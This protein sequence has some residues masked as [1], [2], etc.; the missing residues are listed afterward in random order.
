MNLIVAVDKNWGIGK[1]NDLLVSIPEDMKFFKEMT[2][3]KIIIMGRK[4]LE[5]FPKKK[6]LPNRVNIV[7]SRDKNYLVDG[8]IV[9][10]SLEDAFNYVKNTY[11]EDKLRETFIIGGASIY[12]QAL[13]YCEIAYITHI[14]EEFEADKYFPD[15]H[16]NENWEMTRYEAKVSENGMNFAFAV[17]ENLK[18]KQF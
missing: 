15:I 1:D 7:I 13:D 16:D 11:G 8:A 9:V 10:N 3:G 5:S 17:Y 14:R 12:E 6:P 2:T 4:T 18:I